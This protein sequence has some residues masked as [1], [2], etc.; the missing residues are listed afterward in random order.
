MTVHS[1]VCV[2]ITLATRG[3]SP[4]SVHE[5]LSRRFYPVIDLKFRT[6]TCRQIRLD[7]R[8]TENPAYTLMHPATSRF[9]AIMPQQYIIY[10]MISHIASVFLFFY[11]QNCSFFSTQFSRRTCQGTQ[12]K[13][14]NAFCIPCLLDI[15]SYP[16][17]C[18][19]IKQITI[20]L[21]FTSL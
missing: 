3:P 16:V 11:S 13:T 1:P 15:N 20:I 9:I 8:S 14:E 5:K 17:S 21:F 18:P 10:T 12:T 4:Q 7:I 6:V 2:L 19:L